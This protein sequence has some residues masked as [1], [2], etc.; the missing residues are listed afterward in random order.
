[1]KVK[2][3]YQGITIDRTQASRMNS[4]TGRYFQSRL[5]LSSHATELFV[6]LH[7]ADLYEL[8]TTSDWVPNRPDV[9]DRFKSL[10]E[11][12]ELSNLLVEAA[13]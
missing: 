13:Y 5:D 6:R 1:M 9:E 4:Q 3:S 11:I 8:T 12:L 7:I 10:L 2:S